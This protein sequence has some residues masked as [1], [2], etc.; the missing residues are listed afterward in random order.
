MDTLREYIVKNIENDD[1]YLKFLKEKNSFFLILERLD[2]EKD[3]KKIRLSDIIIKPDKEIWINI[4]YNN[5]F[6]DNIKKFK[7]FKFDT[8]DNKDSFCD[9]FYKCKYGDDDLE[10]CKPV[11]EYHDNSD[12]K[13][14]KYDGQK[15]M[16]K[17]DDIGTFTSR[18]GCIKVKFCN[19]YEGM[20]QEGSIITMKFLPKNSSPEP[21]LTEDIT[22]T[23]DIILDNFDAKEFA[24]K[25]WIGFDKL[26]NQDLPLYDRLNILVD[27]TEETDKILKEQQCKNNIYCN[28]FHTMRDDIAFIK[29]LL[30][31]I[32]CGA[33]LFF[34]ITNKW[35]YLL[36]YQCRFFT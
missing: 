19:M 4:D 31:S 17:Y 23:E 15:L 8:K 29:S 28:S 36:S 35:D 11:I 9:F 13:K 5:Y 24:F 16:G 2:E 26:Y 6:I 25:Y 18:D 32:G 14:I 21:E 3:M 30:K 27:K 34:F 20:T 1:F 7:R 10:I 22:L 12:N 33:V